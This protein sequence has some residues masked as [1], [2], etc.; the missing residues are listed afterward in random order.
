MDLLFFL[1]ALILSIGALAI[2]VVALVM[3]WRGRTETRRLAAVV[4]GLSVRV[5]GL[6][7]AVRGDEAAAGNAL[8]MAPETMSVLSSPVE[9]VSGPLEPAD[10]HPSR[11]SIADEVPTP[12]VEAE[13]ED[14]PPHQASAPAAAREAA[15]ENAEHRFGRRWTVW[16]GALA[17]GL[18]IL[19]LVRYSIENALLT[20]LARVCA[21]YALAALFLLGGELGRRRE[22]RRAAPDP[23]GDAD[24]ATGIAPASRSRAASISAALT[25]AGLAGAFGATYAA[26]GLYGLMGPGLA[27]A[28]LGV[29]GVAALLLSTLHGPILAAVG[30]VGSY[31]TPVLVSSQSEAVWTLTGFLCAI[32]A[33]CLAIARID[34]GAFRR[35]RHEDDASLPPRRSAPSWLPLAVAFAVG[36]WGTLLLLG[37]E[38]VAASVL[39]A[40][41][42]L[43]APLLELALPRAAASART[44]DQAAPDVR[45]PAFASAV[46]ADLV[47]VGVAS[48]LL[49]LCAGKDDAATWVQIAWTLAI[50]VLAS[51]RLDRGGARVWAAPIALAGLVAGV[52][53]P[54]SEAMPALDVFGYDGLRWL[55]TYPDP[56][57]AQG[58]AAG[59]ALVAA[60]VWGLLLRRHAPTLRVAD[61]GLRTAAAGSLAGLGTIL[62]L[63]A[64]GEAALWGTL[65]AALTAAALAAG[66]RAAMSAPDDEAPD[67]GSEDDSDAAGL[68]ATLENG[69][70]L[71]FG[72]WAAAFVACALAV[73]RTELA[74]AVGVLTLLAA[75]L[76][77]RTRSTALRRVVATSAVAT[78]LSA[79]FWFEAAL[80]TR[81][82]LVAV[83][84]G[85][86]LPTLL[87][88]GATRLLRGM[89]GPRFVA[90]GAAVA[91]AAATFAIAVR[92]LATGGDL[93]ASRLGLIE[94]SGY[95]VLALALAF[96]LARMARAG[97]PAVVGM[98][99]DAMAWVGVAS[100]VGAHVLALNPLID[101]TAVPRP[102]L[103]QLLV[104]HGLVGL[105]AALVAWASPR[106]RRRTLY[107]GTACVLGLLW[108][109]LEVRRAFQGPLIGFWRTTSEAELWTYSVVWLVLAVAALAI[110]S[111]LHRSVLRRGGAF[112]L[113]LTTL[114]VFALDA[115]GLSDLYRVASFLGLGLI[116]LAVA[117]LY[118]TRERAAE[119]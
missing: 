71:A 96:A 85:L 69:W 115:A 89:D 79:L 78:G 75:A 18:G 97:R 67:A 4:E 81:T 33:V 108:V 49:A 37:G 2:P 59:V 118:Q 31:A 26:H 41:A 3:A 38:A 99:G 48:V 28:L 112:L 110:S 113:A 62:T 22:V 57:R 40:V 35:R 16:I 43:L 58:A 101:G 86:G 42:G 29:T 51:L 92:V 91:L 82:S 23:A 36:A 39:A 76:A 117:R 19:F 15:R 8:E 105:L 87:V 14:G 84:V 66:F 21:G 46:R 17:L 80:D 63:M 54:A 45:Q 73:E 72:A 50:L 60:L 77:S 10:V 100:I 94:Q 106:S 5:A 6:E 107:G 111:M 27:F 95:T 13:A 104:G 70:P 56:A 90:E 98:V 88:G 30:V 47:L 55:A 11:A 12:S 93:D 1:L 102:L 109:S 44:E 114:K 52:L 119:R 20:P 116:L 64:P 32:T 9:P 103:N 68:A 74:L 34:G 25:A 7:A 83:L 53:G 61:L 65:L 24:A